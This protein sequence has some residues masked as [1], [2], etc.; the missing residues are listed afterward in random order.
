MAFQLI[1]RLLPAEY[2]VLYTEFSNALD[3]RQSI[4][5]SNK[6]LRLNWSTDVPS[7]RAGRW[8]DA[9][10]RIEA[11]YR[12]KIFHKAS[13]PDIVDLLAKTQK[14]VSERAKQMRRYAE[15]DHG[16]RETISAWRQ[17]EEFLQGWLRTR[18]AMRAEE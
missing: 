4:A 9:I 5:Q 14:V 8:P 3:R 17:H 1:P 12:D 6:E 13:I 18:N 10:K 15:N 2:G 16:H 11:I 7:L